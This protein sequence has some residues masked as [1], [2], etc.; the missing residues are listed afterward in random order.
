MDGSTMTAGSVACIRNV[1]NPVKVARLVMEKVCF[2]ILL[3]F[4]KC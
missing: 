2:L 1:A 3:N 4:L